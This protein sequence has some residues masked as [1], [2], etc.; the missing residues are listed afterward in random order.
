M[1]RL[2]VD[3]PAPSD[4]DLTPPL[5]PAAEE[6]GRASLKEALRLARVESAERADVVGDLRSAEL[7]RLD[8]LHDALRPVLAAVPADADMF[9]AGLVGGAHPRLFVDTIAFVDMGRD[10]RLYRFQQDTR[11]GRTMLAESERVGPIVDAVTAYLARRLVEREKALAALPASAL[12]DAEAEAIPA[13]PPRRRRLWRVA[14]AVW[15]FLVDLLGTVALLLLL[16]LGLWY[17]GLS[18]L[19]RANG[20]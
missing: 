17:A 1:G 10:R 18:L 2:G 20:S 15:T 11:L 9:D 6:A 5:D 12:A 19:A 14:G 8:I 4:Y 3:P 16:L 7:A 13:V